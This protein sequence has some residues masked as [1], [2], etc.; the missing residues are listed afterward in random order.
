MDF[1]DYDTFQNDTDPQENNGLPEPAP[2]LIL[3]INPITNKFKNLSILKNHLSE[4]GGAGDSDNGTG[5]N[6]SDDTTV[7]NS[8]IAEKYAKISIDLLNS[9]NQSSNDDL[10]TDLPHE[11]SSNT[12]I[13]QSD[14][15]NNHITSKASSHTT[16]TSVL[17]T[18]L[19]KVLNTYDNNDPKL[20][21]AIQLLQNK[22]I[23]D[24]D[25]L[26]KTDLLGS[27]ARRNFRSEIEND[28]L[29]QHSNVLKEFQPIIHKIE[30]IGDKIQKLN[31]INNKF[32]NF[33]KLNPELIN[34]IE[35]LSIQKTIL[36]LKKMIL[37]NFKKK[38]TLTQF[39]EHV[40][41]NEE[42]SINFF[43]VLSKYSNDDQSRPI[44]LSAHDPLRYIGDILAY[45][46][47]TMVNEVEF[48]K[49]LFAKEEDDEELS[50]LSDLEQ[51]GNI[52]NDIINEILNS[53]ARPLK[54]RIEQI[55]RN[56]INLENIGKFFN[57]FELFKMMYEKNL[58]LEIIPNSQ[59]IKNLNNLEKITVEKIFNIMKEKLI[60]IKNGNTVES[61][62][63]LLLPPDW[64]RDYLTDVLVLFD[65]VQFGSDEHIFKLS[66]D[67]FKS[68]LKTIIN[69][70]IDIL[71]SIS[72]NQILNKTDQQ[73][74]QLNCLDLI[75]SK[76]IT[77]PQFSS[78]NDELNDSITEL[79]LKL[80][81]NQYNLLLTNSQLSI[82]QQLIQLIFPIDQIESK[83]DYM[84]YSSL[85]E[86]KLFH[87]EK[88]L[89]IELKLHDFL[90]IALI[91]FQQSLFKISS[92]ILANDIIIESSLKFLNLYLVFYNI[93]LELYPDEKILEWN[94][95][96]VATLLGVEEDY[97]KS[98]FASL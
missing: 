36:T 86:N 23:M 38:F 60:I 70:P 18:K 29:K 17:S 61:N 83:D 40:L 37:L 34:Q 21:E 49:I 79:K 62:D 24:I 66:D 43:S 94:P 6:N 88:L 20:R 72:Q 41:T 82:H 7:N 59:I 96:D 64:I 69:E 80:I 84:M 50:E 71:T 42:I 73:I 8:K 95:Y 78:K 51:L 90:P 87:K 4:G 77:I 47:S 65:N 93:L 58:P 13:D 9:N 26:V 68:L 5:N 67:E 15:L 63:D 55:I 53:L 52:T 44:V 97:K 89:E 14:K 19:S 10:I 12:K 32:Q 54:I 11:N 98:S 35:K 45:I 85:I 92:P 46:H 74:F 1:I 3:P 28:L 76:I 57:L 91:E 56:E 48:I 30:N 16:S 2:P 81:E 75:Q 39:D 22:K 27:I 31:N 33:D 25:Q